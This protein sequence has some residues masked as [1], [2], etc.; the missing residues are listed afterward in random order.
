MPWLDKIFLK[1]PIRLWLDRQGYFA[2]KS[3]IAAF[4]L[5][6]RRERD[7]EKQSNDGSTSRDFLSRF[8]EAHKKDP[9]FIPQERVT[10]LTVA[11]IFAGSDT[12]AISLRAIFYFLLQ[13]PTK[14][15][16]LMNEFAVEE[17]AGRFA[18]ADGL[19]GW[20]ETRELPYLSAVIKEAL[21]CHPAVGLTLE[22]IV[23]P[24]G[25]AI[26]GHFL[27]G[28]TIV[29]CSPWTVHRCKS[30]FG[31]DSEAFRPE[32]W[33]EAD[34]AK[35]SEMNGFL[36]TFG[37]GSRTCIGKNISYLEM[38]KLVP[39]ILRVFELEFEDPNTPWTLHNAW[40][41]KQE[42]FKVRFKTR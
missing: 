11:N 13:N 5:Q 34:D 26:G 14:L 37:A 12:T 33:L 35:A 18:R 7:T 42:N 3:P 31:K 22:R 2:T 8:L 19:V 15:T 40:F 39:A 17:K 6:R 25:I 30:V 27:P 41:V 23:P 29:G 10:A 1:N 20:D 28:G 32:R 4:A 36:F 21:R 24:Q 38:Y 9:D 16:K